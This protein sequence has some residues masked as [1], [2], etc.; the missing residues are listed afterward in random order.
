MHL[1]QSCSQYITH[2]VRRS[3]ILSAKIFEKYLW[4]VVRVFAITTIVFVSVKSFVLNAGE[5]NGRSMEPMFVDS[6]KFLVSKIEYFVAPPRRYDVVQLIDEKNS[7]L[8]IKRVIGLPNETIVIKQGRVFVQPFGALTE[9]AIEEPY[10]S[11][12]TYTKVP[13]Q[14]APKVFTMGSDEYFVLGDHRAQSADSRDYGAVHR[15]QILGRVIGPIS[16]LDR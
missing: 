7:K 3:T 13:F 2:H 6:Q 12:G 9:R 1:F 11:S 10:L 14:N 5:V 4:H 8:I 15:S 16:M